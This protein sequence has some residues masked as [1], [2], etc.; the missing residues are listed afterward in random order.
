MLSD[1]ELKSSYRSGRDP[2]LD[3]F[4][5]PCLEEAI[6]YDRAVGYFSSS[7][8]HVV[9]IAYSDFALRGGRFR[10]LCSPALSPADYDAMRSAQETARLMHESIRSQLSE[11]LADPQTVPATKLLATLISAGIMDV[12]IAF[13]ADPA[14]IFHDKLGIFVDAEGR[15]VTFVGSANETW[16]A[17]GLNHESFEV[18]CSWRGERELLRTRN[19]ALYFD[20]LWES[21]EP[22]VRVEHLDSVTREQLIAFAD[23]SVDRAIDRVR[24]GPDVMPQQV[25]SMF[26][27]Q[28]AVLESWRE[29]GF[30]GIVNFATGAGKTL[31]AITAI[32]EWTN[33]GKPALVIVPGRDLH[34][35]WVSELKMEL[36]GIRLLLAGAGHPRDDWQRL[37]PTFLRS[38]SP[39]SP[40]AVVTTMQTFSSPQF[41]DRALGSQDL[42]FVVDEL[43]RAGTQRTLAGLEQMPNAATMGL[44]ATYEREWD[45]PGTKRL[46]A[47]L[48]PV[49][50]PVIGLAEAIA[51]GLL[52]PY[53]YRLHTLALDDDE[54]M[55]YEQLTDRIRRL[56]A[57]S[58]GQIE[59]DERITLLLIQRARILKQARGKVSKAF[60]ILQAEYR[61]GD[62]W[63][64]YCD[65]QDQLQ[66]V[67]G[68][69]QDNGLPV[70]EYHSQMAGDRE[71]VLPSLNVYGGIVVAIRCLDEGVDIPVCDKALIIASSTVE[72]EYIQRRGRVLRRAPDKHSATVHDLLVTDSGGGALTRSE[73]KRALQF[74]RLARNPGA[75]ARLH[76]LLALSNDVEGL[77]DVPEVEPSEEEE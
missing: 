10:L 75:R 24:R 35:Q 17:W 19:H 22:G 44:S 11:L 18:F 28:V 62:R 48:G 64:V 7:L 57:Q 77:G 66:A 12:R 59:E 8:L 67:V 71:P 26:P 5:V 16:A 45:A 25:R 13:S 49:L 76:L 63:L 68:M 2:L 72:R 27:H 39:A 23:E 15:R 20:A 4:Y 30:R 61:T 34:R 29:A 1:L 41:Q 46:V 50:E 9:A 21:K 69:A 32:K 51:F 43:H 33:S 31:T 38:T 60:E 54:L 40:H 55:A 56:A 42:F 70:M 3:A 73:A 52:V 36:P 65:S 37:L 74:A 53:D 14:G 58:D 6:A 47:V